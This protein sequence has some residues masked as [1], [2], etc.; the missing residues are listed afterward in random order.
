MF[1]LAFVA[2]VLGYLMLL[3]LPG[4][5]AQMAL[6]W[7]LTL[8]G[9]VGGGGAGVVYHLRLHAAL[10][11]VGAGTRGWLW[12]PVSRHRHLDERGRARVLPWFRAG[13]AGFV[14]CVGGIGMV[15]AAVARAL[16]AAR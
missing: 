7:A 12:A 16:A 9:L 2:A 4:P 13:A 1:E 10:L 11:R 14:V 8:L 15:V 5:E 3:A 6:G